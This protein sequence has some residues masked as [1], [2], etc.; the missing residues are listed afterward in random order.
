MPINYT[1]LL[2]L[3]II[4]G[5]AFNISMQLIDSAWML[6]YIDCM[7]LIAR[8]TEPI[9]CYDSVSGKDISIVRHDIYLYSVVP[10]FTL[11][12]V[13]ILRSIKRLGFRWQVIVLSYLSF[14]FIG[15]FFIFSKEYGNLF[16]KIT[17]FL[18]P[19][20]Y[21]AV[22]ANIIIVL[23]ISWFLYFSKTIQN[24]IQKKPSF[25]SER[26]NDDILDF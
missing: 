11:N 17:F 18:I 19:N 12:I 1:S 20:T 21:I 23:F 7:D 24:F 3:I 4:H 2:K 26:Y 22:Y 16:Y 6:L 15:F 10:I 8:S 9:N 5:I 13:F 14:A 25:Y